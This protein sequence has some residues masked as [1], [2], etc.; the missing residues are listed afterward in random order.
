MLVIVGHPFSTQRSQ[1]GTDAA[2]KA[3]D[4]AWL[5]PAPS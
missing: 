4:Q 5:K 3:D 1:W 2:A